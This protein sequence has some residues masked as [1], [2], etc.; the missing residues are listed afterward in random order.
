MLRELEKMCWDCAFDVSRASE[1][2]KHVDL[3][4]EFISSRWKKISY[5]TV[6]LNEAVLSNNIRMVRL[7]LENGAS[8]DV[9]FDDGTNS[10]LW[11]L[12]Y[13]GDDAPED[14]EIRLQMTQLLLEYGAD[15]NIVTEDGWEDLFTWVAFSVFNDDHG[16][17]W[18]YLSYFFVLLVAYGGKSDYC[19]P[20]I[21]GN[22]DK[23]AM[24]QYRFFLVP[25]GDGKYSGVILDGEGNIVARL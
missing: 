13:P 16:D 17:L 8:P 19:I 1:I 22:F 20:E 2:I 24:R 12:Q 21:I 23:T 5:K 14:D 25:E 4:R 6:F 10:L 7:L 9:L 3:D 15:T 18:R 11:S